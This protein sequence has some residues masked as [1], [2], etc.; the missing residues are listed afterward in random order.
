MRILYT[1]YCIIKGYGDNLPFSKTRYI[2]SYAMSLFITSI[3]KEPLSP[4]SDRNYWHGGLSKVLT[5]IIMP[6]HQL[7][8]STGL[9]PVSIEYLMTPANRSTHYYKKEAYAGDGDLFF[10]Q[11]MNNFVMTKECN[12]QTNTWSLNN[13]RF[14]KY[15]GENVYCDVYINGKK[16]I[17]RMYPHIRSFSH[18]DNGLETYKVITNVKLYRRRE[19][20]SLAETSTA[21]DLGCVNLPFSKVINLSTIKEF[22]FDLND[23]RKVRVRYDAVA[24]Y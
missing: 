7:R 21:I 23:D 22:R 14:N 1:F 10:P 19:D 9:E 11:N 13:C 5:I 16:Y 24:V 15:L 18:I 6:M 17:A 4:H 20:T 2:K 12:G 3:R 8:T